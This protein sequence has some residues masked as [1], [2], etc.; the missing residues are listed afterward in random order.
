MRLNEIVTIILDGPN[1]KQ[2]GPDGV[3]G[4][5]LKR[6]ARQ[7]APIFQEAWNDLKQDV[8]PD[9]ARDCLARKKWVVIPKVDGANHTNQLRDLELGN[10]IRQVLARILF[11]VLDEVCQDNV[12]GLTQA[13]QAFLSGREITRNTTKIGRLFWSAVEEAA[14]ANPFFPLACPRLH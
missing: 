5:V 4:F 11:K 9:A 8:A 2:P 10:E 12:T 6:Y 1:D 3:P 7:M 13:Q 14:V